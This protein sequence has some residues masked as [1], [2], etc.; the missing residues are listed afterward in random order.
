MCVATSVAHSCVRSRRTDKP[1]AVLMMAVGTGSNVLCVV[2]VVVPDA[3]SQV[4]KAFA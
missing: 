2:S 4:Y 1:V 3:L